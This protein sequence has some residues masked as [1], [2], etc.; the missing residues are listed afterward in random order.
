M[1][2]SQGGIRHGDQRERDGGARFHAPAET[3]QTAIAA[4]AL[5]MMT[6]CLPESAPKRISRQRREIDTQRDSLHA[7]HPQAVYYGVVVGRMT[8]PG[9][10]STRPQL[11]TRIP[12]RINMQTAR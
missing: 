2:L 4:S 10:M 8:T 7:E 12:A 11:I 6:A 3:E 9:A 1:R 5:R